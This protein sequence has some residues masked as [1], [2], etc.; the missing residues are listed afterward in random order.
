MKLLISKV[1]SWQSTHPPFRN[2]QPAVQLHTT[3]PSSDAQTNSSLYLHSRLASSILVQTRR[4]MDPFSD[5][6]AVFCYCTA[7]ALATLVCGSSSRDE[8]T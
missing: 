4:G 3:T 8:M 7:A 1:C 5:L 2:I 6:A